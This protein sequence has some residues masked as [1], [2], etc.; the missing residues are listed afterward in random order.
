MQIDNKMRIFL[1]AVLVAVMA[2]AA[3]YYFNS[4]NSPKKE[5]AQAEDLRVNRLLVEMED[6]SVI[7]NQEDSDAG[8]I[9]AD[10]NEINDLGN[11]A[12]ENEF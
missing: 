1:A 11:S 10:D 4:V 7:T 9:T 8:L 5:A 2:I 3:A 12:E 6:E